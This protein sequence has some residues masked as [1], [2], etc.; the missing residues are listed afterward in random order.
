MKAPINA[1][2]GLPGSYRLP[3]RRLNCAVFIIDYS[4]SSATTD[5]FG[6]ISVIPSDV[7]FAL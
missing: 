4:T 2:K 1:A 5:I 3:E 6:T 7:I